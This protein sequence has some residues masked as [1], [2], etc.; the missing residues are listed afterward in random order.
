MTESAR[1]E[2]IANMKR[3]LDDLDANIDELEKKAGKVEADAR[4]EYEQRLA[5]MKEKRRQVDQK[6]DEIRAAGEGGWNALKQEA[7]HTWKALQNSFNYFTSHY[8]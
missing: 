8:K 4:K 5:D 2:F 3:R 1:K 7:E 6:L